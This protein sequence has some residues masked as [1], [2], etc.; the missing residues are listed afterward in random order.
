MSFDRFVFQRM[1]VQGVVDWNPRAKVLNVGCH[2]DGAK[3][4]TTFLDN[5]LNTDI[6][7]QPGYDYKADLLFDARLPW[8]VRCDGAVL[9][10]MLEHHYDHE[11][12]AIFSEARDA[13][14]CCLVLTWPE[15][16][17]FWRDGLIGVSDSMGYRSHCNLITLKK[18]SKLLKHVGFEVCC[19][20]AGDQG[21]EYSGTVYR[22][23]S[24]GVLA[25]QA[26]FEFGLGVDPLGGS[27]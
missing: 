27:L 26:G 16:D 19:A 7:I 6:E 3:L 23:P 12:V 9:A 21:L 8:P 4:R 2:D 13:G 14:A 25:A 24:R 20:V 18:M 10:D 11:I 15:D 5:V 1:G 22:V 17:F